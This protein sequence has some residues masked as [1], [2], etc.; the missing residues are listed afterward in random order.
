MAALVGKR[1]INLSALEKFVVSFGLSIVCVNAIMLLLGFFDVPITKSSFLVS[2]IIFSL[3]C[4]IVSKRTIPPSKKAQPAEENGHFDSLYSWPYRKIL[5]FV[6]ILFLA[7]LFRSF[8]MSRGIMPQTTDLGHHMYWAKYITEFSVLPEYGMPDFIIGEH[9]IFAATSFV[10][11]MPFFSTMPVIVLLIINIFS[12][13]A[14]FILTFRF[15][16]IFFGPKN[17][18]KIALLAL[19]VIGCL[20]AISSPQAKFVSG[21]VVGNIMGNLLIPL[22]VYFLIRT[23]QEK[24]VVF[25]QLFI[26][27]SVALVYT[28]HLSM[29]VL[30]YVLAGSFFASLL[31][32]LFK[33][34]KSLRQFFYE[35][36][37]TLLPFLHVRTLAMIVVAVFFILI[38]HTPS[39]LNPS[40]I[41]TAVGEPI[42]ATRTGLTLNNITL[43]GGPWRF[44]YGAM[45]VLFLSLWALPKTLKKTTRNLV[46]SVAATTITFIAWLAIIFLM[47]WKPALLNVDIPSNRIASYITY[48]LSILSAFGVYFLIDNSRK[49]LSAFLYSMVLLI[50]LGTGFI[51]GYSDVSDSA[52]IRDPLQ[53]KKVR[54]TYLASEYLN[55]IS[56]VDEQVLKDHIYLEGDTWIKLFFMRGYKY[57]LSR[58][59]LKRYEDPTKNR[60]TCTRDM[61]AIPDSETGIDCFNETGVKYVML[62]TEKDTAQFEKSQSFNKIYTSDHVTIFER[63]D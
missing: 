47:S 54:Q 5:I 38:V 63:I 45:G 43:S 44:F 50:I 18:K 19:F 15:A 24:R 9:L 10:S 16:A 30:L 59:F 27:F 52:R 57:P 60:E 29:F 14:V 46:P 20:Y 33:F 34:R 8:Y 3:L 13:L 49:K 58:S 2:I 40:A 4:V 41:D 28:H 55:S 1:E 6:V 61:V 11:G 26:I 39:Y 12:L 32:L 7:I 35:I 51:S 42:K 62:N 56:K 36:K 53:E 48:P 31:F 17:S 25:A 23:I 37:N 21:G 22:V